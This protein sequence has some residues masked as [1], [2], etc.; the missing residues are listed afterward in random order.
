M[1]DVGL[2]TFFSE[3]ESIINS[4]PLTPVSFVE[5]LVRPLTPNDLLLICPGYDLLPT[6]TK[7]SDVIFHDRWR[8]GQLYADL[9]WKRWA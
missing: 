1:T 4:R 8:Q 3:V 7:A 6:E 2:I 5:D 9:F